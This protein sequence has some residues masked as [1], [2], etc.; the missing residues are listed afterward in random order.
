MTVLRFIL[1]DQLGRGLSALRDLAPGDVVLMAEVADETVYVPHHKQKIALVL[2]AMRHFAADLAAEG[3]EVDYV[4]LDDP[5][6]SGSFTGELARAVAC[7]RP[8]RV[9]VTEP[10][11]WRVQRMI[12]GWETAVGLPVEIRPDDRF[13]C[14]RDRFA[15][16]AEGRKSLRMEFFYR[17]MRRETGFLMEGGEPAGGRWNF[18]AENRKSLPA[19][20]RPPP[21]RR[22]EPDAITREVLALVAARFPG[23][24]GDL[25]PFGWAVTRADAL[26]ALEH[27]VEAC[28]PLY[29]DYQDAMKAGE[30]FLYHA[31]LSPY[32]NLGL[33]DPGEVCLAAETAWRRGAAPLNAA[34]GFVRQILGWRE[35][36]RG[37]YWLRMPGYA[38]TNHLGAGRP[39]P[40]FYWSGE[41]AMACIAEVV[42]ET[43]RNAYA[44]HIQRLMVTGNFALLAGLAPAEVEAWYL[45]VYADAYDWVELPNTHGMVLHAD[46]GLMASKPYAAS[47]AYIDRMSD[48]CAGCAYD[49][50]VKT[51]PRACPFNLL[52][53]NFLM[54]NRPKLSA[55]PR[56]AMPYRTLDRMTDSRRATIRREA[57]AFLA[58]LDAGPAAPPAGDQLAMDFGA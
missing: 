42:A 15:R 21:R 49:P 19:G 47:G 8:V 30:P 50:A 2:S 38:A 26:E 28:L 22:F 27:F 5:A 31:V 29:G 16:W 57:G 14:S 6:N 12:E 11:E 45:A 24:F 40:W 23:H 13:L 33:L 35:Y 55:N 51:G 20:Q 46:G 32:L 48:Y 58:A 56:L 41:T 36:V 1:G 44:H 3:I 52:Y 17:E 4:R 53:W 10:G 25:E 54:E 34:E 43:R 39:L 9:V 7:R 18:D 37:I